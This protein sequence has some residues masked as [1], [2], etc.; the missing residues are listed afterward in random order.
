MSEKVRVAL[1]C[2]TFLI[3]K[4]AIYPKVICITVA[5]L[6]EEQIE[7]QLYTAAQEQTPFLLEN[8]FSDPNIEIVGCNTKYDLACIKNTWSNLTSL[9]WQML[10]DGRITDIS[11]REK[12]LN[13]T[14]SGLI[15]IAELPDG[16]NHKL[17]YSLEA[18]VRKYLGIDLAKEK[19]DP[20]AWRLRFHELA[21]KLPEEYPDAAKEYALLDAEFTLLVAAE[22]DKLEQNPEGGPGSMYTQYFQT[23]S[24]FAL[25]MFTENGFCI[26]QDEVIKVEKM[27]DEE[28]TPEKMQLLIKNKVLRPAVPPQ[29]Y[30]NGALN[31]DGTLKMR[32]A[33]PESVN[34]TVLGE[35]IKTTAEDNDLEVKRTDPTDKFPE[36]QIATS[37]AI[38]DEL[39]ALNPI[40]T[41]YQQR[42]KVMK[43][44]TSYIPN[45]KEGM[46]YANYDVLKET[47]RTSSYGG[48]L[49]PSWNGQ[50]VDPRVRGCCIP[51]EGYLLVSV[52]YS[53]I[54]LVSLAQTIYSMFG[55]STLRDLILQGVDP[56]AYLG[57]QLAYHLDQEI[58]FREAV[59][60]EISKVNP[61]QI[62]KCFIECKESNDERLQ[63]FFEHYR[64]LA[65]PTGLGYPGGL[66]PAKFVTYA[67]TT[68]DVIVTEEQSIMM[69][70]LW[71]E[72]FPEMRE[73][74]AALNKQFKDPVNPDRYCY[75]TPLGMYRAGATYCAAANGNA[76]QSP[77]AE[78]AKGGVFDV[79]RAC[80]DPA[81]KSILYGCRPLLFIHDEQIIEIPD[82]TL[83]HD[84]AME[85][86]R[87]MEQAMKAVLYD[88]DPQA[89]P[90]LMRRWNKTAKP[91]YINN[92]LVIWEP[93]E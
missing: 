48:D 81:E 27:I 67:K 72:A 79:A 58:G 30:K 34:K 86:K 74:F 43:L 49:Y 15:D 68:Y 41:E 24:D 35:I 66:G 60:A 18:L 85:I 29:P 82:D 54:E 22:Q 90:C 28:L 69:R 23:A 61:M 37:A 80:C 50:Q 76:L 88:M 83:A 40:L 73:Y 11:I 17:R 52:D 70:E 19:N 71:H 21:G 2:E 89:E 64:K 38:I 31:K 8:L 93:K 25:G 20:E 3:G 14:T 33:K 59:D 53:A 62:Y 10:A 45:L 92:K 9:I 12:L 55:R 84:R 7:R 44:K 87:L 78:G 91:V 4:E 6:G 56:H 57:A 32:K 42:Q 26:D 46:V 5:A 47:G 1:D 39:A 63:E 51:R 36:G 75:M 65:K 16:T 13:V 77:T